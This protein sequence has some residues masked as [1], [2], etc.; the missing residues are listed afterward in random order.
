MSAAWALLFRLGVAAT[1]VLG[2][3]CDISVGDAEA[4]DAGDA[5]SDRDLAPPLPPPPDESDAI[6]S[7]M[8]FCRFCA[9]EME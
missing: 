6:C 4:V 2:G 8:M 1:R 9:T 7:W 3:G 5:V